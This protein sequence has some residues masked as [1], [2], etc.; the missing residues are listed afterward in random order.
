MSNAPFDAAYLREL[1]EKCRQL[2]SGLPAEDG[3][4]LLRMAAEYD[5]RAKRIDREQSAGTG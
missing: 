2:A 1:A 4:E 5:A 3:V